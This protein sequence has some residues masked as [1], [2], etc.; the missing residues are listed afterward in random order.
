M[1]NGGWK[2]RGRAQQQVN[3]MEALWHCAASLTDS[4]CDRY[5]RVHKVC[6]AVRYVTWQSARTID[7]SFPM[8]TSKCTARG[9]TV[10]TS[11][12]TKVE[13]ERDSTWR[14]VVWSQ[15][16]GAAPA[17]RNPS[18]NDIPWLSRDGGRE[19]LPSLFP[20]SP[21]MPPVFWRHDFGFSVFQFGFLNKICSFIRFRGFFKLPLKI[22]NRSKM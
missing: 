11:E 22:S 3:G 9:C 21:A 5:E 20:I 6:G 14:R 10:L 2:S 4:V 15:R 1:G 19:G 7:F 8:I 18:R 12:L 13:R 17:Q 16:R